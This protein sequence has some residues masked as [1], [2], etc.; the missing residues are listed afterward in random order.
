MYGLI[1]KT[2]T[3]PGKRDEYIRLMSDGFKNMEGCHS[4][5]FAE[6]TEEED[7]LWITEIWENH[8]AHERAV[9]RPDV[10]AAINDVKARQITIG[11]ELRVVVT[12]VSGQG[13]F[14]DGA[15]R[16]EP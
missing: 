4:Y 10:R 11:R 15:W 9:N 1:I 16:P 13:L 12:P 3:H 5:I 2:R 8:E 7:V 6:D 14:N